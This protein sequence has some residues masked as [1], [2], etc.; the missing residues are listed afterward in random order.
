M[1]RSKEKKRV[2]HSK[3]EVEREYFPKSFE[4]GMEKE[5]T[6]ARALGIS[7]ANEDLEKIR[8]KLQ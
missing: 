8:K 3:M 4:K 6:D 2:F 1:K 5:P 7:W